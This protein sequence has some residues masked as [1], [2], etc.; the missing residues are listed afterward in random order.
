MFKIVVVVATVAG[1]ML[2]ISFSVKPYNAQDCAANMLSATQEVAK[3]FAEKQIVTQTMCVPVEA[4]EALRK[5]IEK[6]NAA[7]DKLYDL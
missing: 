7:T 4:A 6:H 2:G 5:N 1:E 3:S